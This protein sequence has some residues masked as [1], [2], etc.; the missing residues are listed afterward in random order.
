MAQ[1][2]VCELPMMD[3]TQ[4]VRAFTSTCRLFFPTLMWLNNCF[5]KSQ[6]MDDLGKKIKH[7]EKSSTAQNGKSGCA[8][9]S[10]TASMGEDI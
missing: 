6:G 2:K 4:I 1:M 7:K 8:I 10:S 3:W 9:G 5:D